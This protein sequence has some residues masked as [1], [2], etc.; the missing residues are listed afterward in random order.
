[1][2]QGMWG[3]VLFEAAA[4][5]GAPRSDA[6]LAAGMLLSNE[7]GYYEE[8]SDG[9]GVE[10]LVF[11]EDDERGDLRFDTTRSRRIWMRRKCGG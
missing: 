10:N 1:M 4:K 5:G 3:W 9:I 8:G 11:V 6:L 7:A 2:G